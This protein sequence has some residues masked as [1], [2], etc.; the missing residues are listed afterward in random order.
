M[1]I[2]FS[3][4]ILTIKKFFFFKA[5]LDFASLFKQNKI[6]KISNSIAFLECQVTEKI[7]AG[8]HYIYVGKVLEGELNENLLKPLIYQNGLIKNLL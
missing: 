3:L 4:R 2:C 1:F 8:D 7:E 6:K 5:I